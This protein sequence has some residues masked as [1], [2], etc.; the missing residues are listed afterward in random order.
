MVHCVKGY[1]EVQQSEHVSFPVSMAMRIVSSSAT[2]AISGLCPHLN[3]DCEASRMLADVTYLR[4]VVTA[5]LVI[6]PKNGKLKSGWYLELSSGSSV[7]FLRIGKT[8]AFF[9]EFSRERGR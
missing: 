3:P 2:R 5:L 7:S 8:F 9:K 6:L 4:L 1:R